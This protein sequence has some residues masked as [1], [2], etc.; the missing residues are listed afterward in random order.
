MSALLR[1]LP[2]LQR[3]YS[4]GPSREAEVLTK[5]LGAHVAKLRI[6]P[7]ESIALL[8]PCEMLRGAEGARITS[9]VDATLKKSICRTMQA[10]LARTPGS[11]KGI[12]YDH[13]YSREV[14]GQ[15]EETHDIMQKKD[16]I[17]KAPLPCFELG[18]KDLR[19]FIAK[20]GV[21]PSEALHSFLEGPIAADCGSTVEAVYSKAIFDLLGQRKFDAVFTDPQEKFQIRKWIC[22]DIESSLFPFLDFVSPY[23]YAETDPKQLELGDHVCATG[24]P[25]F[26]IKHPF[27][28]MQGMHG[29]VVGF[30]PEQEPLIAGL[31]MQAPRTLAQIYDD[32]LEANNAPQTPVEIKFIEWVGKERYYSSKG[33]D[34]ERLFKQWTVEEIRNIGHLRINNENTCRLS[35]LTLSILKVSSEDAPLRRLAQLSK[36]FQLRSQIQSL[37][38]EEA[39]L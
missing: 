34:Q 5:L 24:V 15:Q 39:L 38:I 18:E 36:A 23:V 25:W 20:D 3:Y 16:E 37:K 6:D 29:L 21:S 8:K 35:T 13:E 4:T 19:H 28:H 26:T 22:P 11:K 32:L 27:G 31:G 30:T 12:M 33:I 10:I 9:A 7:R 2:T 17:K 1:V 14:L